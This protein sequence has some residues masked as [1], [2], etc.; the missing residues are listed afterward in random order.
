MS[1]RSPNEYVNNSKYYASMV[2][3]STLCYAYAD[4]FSQILLMLSILWVYAIIKVCIFI[5]INHV[6]KQCTS[7]II[8]ID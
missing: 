3:L 5:H 2:T 8:T 4:C 7:M 6:S 1:Q